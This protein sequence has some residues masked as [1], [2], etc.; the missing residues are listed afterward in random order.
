MAR[1]IGLTL[2]LATAALVSSFPIAPSVLVKATA[3]STLG[4]ANDPLRLDPRNPHYFLFRGRPTVLVTSG[5]HYGAVINGDFNYV[6][7]LDELQR[8]HLN[9]TRTWAG[10]YREVAGDFA[11]ANNTLAPAPDRFVC[12]WP[13]SAAP[14]AGDG[15]NKFDLS[16]W[17]PA[18]FERLRD[19]VAEASQRGIVV[20][21]NLFCPY[22][23]ESM[24]DVAPLNPR[25]NVNQLG[26]IAR[27]DALTMKHPRLVTLEDRMVRKIAAELRGFDNVYYEICN[28][29]YFGGVT[30]DWQEHI[31]GVI[32]EA[33][34]GIPHSHLISRNVANG[35]VAVENPFARVSILNFHYSR[36]PDSV[37]MN[38]ALDR[39]IG[40]NETGFDG[41]ADSTYRIQGWE[42]LMAGGALYNNL[43]YSF[44]VGHERGDDR[45]PA[46]T[47][48][49]G[50]S[51]LRQQLGSLH[52][53]FDSIPFERMAPASDVLHSGVPAG[54]SARMLAERGVIYVVYIDHA[55]FA[56]DRKPSV[57]VDSTEHRLGLV[58]DLPPGIYTAKWFDP[59]T[60]DVVEPH[61]LLHGGAVQID[62]PPYREDAL[63]LVRG[64]RPANP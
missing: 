10:A 56:K 32:A 60:G 55:S 3:I 13:R 42:F 12:P 29:P 48:G 38:Y 25:N 63:L 54:A 7:Y 52:R 8:N 9:L 43:D 23:K 49:G 6:T 28:E 39:A 51:A 46:T 50:S 4:G 14:G 59:H 30:L 33:E 5:E 26:D 34:S 45:Y 41:N 1:P 15:G 31:A 2:V 58:L 61:R 16:Q 62:S 24:W 18:Y 47:P 20:E 44:T 36:P 35:S 11:I 17:K 21:I 40:N 53:F 57:R 27:T 19:F 64:E 22:D 37:A